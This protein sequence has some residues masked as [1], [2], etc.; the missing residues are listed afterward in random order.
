MLLQLIK[1]RLL[2]NKTHTVILIIS[3]L[4]CFCCIHTFLVI[5]SNLKKGFINHAHLNDVIIGTHNSS[6]NFIK[7]GLLLS[8]SGT[9][10]LPIKKINSDIIKYQTPIYLGENHKNFNI[11]G[12]NYNFF[13]IIK[14]PINKISIHNNDAI[15][16]FNVAKKLGYKQSDTLHINHNSHYH[17]HN[18]F[19]VIKILPKLN[20]MLDNKV[21]IN[22]KS[23]IAMHNN[24]HKI[25]PHYIWAS[26]TKPML[27]F[28]LK[29]QLEPS[30][31][32]FSAK[33]SKKEFINTFKPLFFILK[34]IIFCLITITSL[35]IV[36]YTSNKF[37]LLKKEIII[38][39]N[40]GA[41]KT[42]ITRSIFY[43]FII[44]FLVSLGLS[45]GLSYVHLSSNKHL[46][47]SLIM[48]PINTYFLSLKTYTMAIITPLF[49]ML[50]VSFLFAKRIY[51]N[52]SN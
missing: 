15:L 47:E 40:Y 52:E 39:K 49:L 14:I 22:E 32:V 3:F 10:T 48:F 27:F 35:Q 16:G 51:N 7:N 28:N 11:V 26:L 2:A 4:I 19:K 34:L 46:Y 13:K 30:Y 38:L 41:K 50:I 36:F 44:I 12:T 18:E 20:N 42:F 24:H 5:H 31:K 29:K 43:E 25:Y 6:T 45:I 8:S 17:T 1:K 37:T 9:T 21:F 33:F 23:F